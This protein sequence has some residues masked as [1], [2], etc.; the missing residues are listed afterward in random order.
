MKLRLISTMVVAAISLTVASTASA[1]SW[2]SLS[3]AGT[4]IL[5]QEGNQEFATQGIKIVCEEVSA[6]TFIPGTGVILVNSI[7]ALVS[8]NKC[9][10]FGFRAALTT[11]ELLL[12]ANGS[13][14][15]GNTDKFVITPVGAK[16]SI[17]ILTESQTSAPLLGTIK[18][19]NVAGGIQGVANATEIPIIVRG[20][21]T[22]CGTNGTAK[23]TYSGNATTELLSGHITVE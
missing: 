9:E 14:R 5:K 2:F 18:Y 4:V 20:T 16:C 17:Q 21:G 22:V 11:G 1:T 7:R 6:S 19:T 13:I 10:W 15:V 8:Y 3:K 12:D 23:A